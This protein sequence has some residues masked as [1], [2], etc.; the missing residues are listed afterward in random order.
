MAV[1]TL[2]VS[3]SPEEIQAWYNT[4]CFLLSLGVMVMLTNQIHKWSHTYNGLPAWVEWLQRTHL[5]LPKKHHRVH[6]VAPHETYFCITTGWLNYPLHVL[7][8][9]KTLEYIIEWLT[10]CKP[11]V[12]DL[13]WAN[14]TDMNA[15]CGSE[16]TP[17]ILN[18]WLNYII[19]CYVCMYSHSSREPEYYTSTAII[20]AQQFHN[21]MLHLQ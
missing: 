14:M 3:N 8:F 2:L 10:G 21:D 1:Y 19:S 16:D 13:K 15:P 9:W 18:S 5:I 12:D 4:Y 11:R 17:T 7:H 20:P 6:H